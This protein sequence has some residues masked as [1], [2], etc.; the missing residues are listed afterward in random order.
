MQLGIQHHTIADRHAAQLHTPAPLAQHAALCTTH[1]ASHSAQP[2]FLFLPSTP[3]LHTT[4][5]QT[6]QKRAVAPARAARTTRSVSVVARASTAQKSSTATG[7]TVLARWVWV[8]LTYGSGREGRRKE[9]ACIG[10]QIGW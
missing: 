2:L 9:G 4:N 6:K 8:V 7:L 1:T 10:R 3:S 5:T